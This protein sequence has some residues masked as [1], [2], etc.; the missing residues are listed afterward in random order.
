MIVKPETI[1]VIMCTYNGAEF[2][3]EQID[4]IINQVEKID[5]LLIIDDL[6]T[7]NTIQKL[8]A[9][10][11]K[12]PQLIKVIENKENLGYNKNFEKALQLASGTLIAIADQD[13]IWLPE[14]VKKLTNCFTNPQVMLAHCR[15]V[16]LQN[17]ELLYSRAKLHHHFTGNDSRQFFFFNHVMGHD[18]MLR[19]SLI[20]KA[21]PIPTGVYY[22]WWLAVQATCN[23]T[24]KGVDE[25]LTKHRI[26]NTNSFFNDSKSINNIKPNILFILNAFSNIKNLSAN[27]EGFLK[28]LINLL[29]KKEQQNKTGFYY[30]LFKFLLKNRKVVFAHKK[31]A[32]PFISYIKNA[33]KY[34]TINH[35]P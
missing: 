5:E 25:Y 23:G 19:K 24:I 35:I 28:E 10:Q 17:G 7:D 12:Y 22:D 1:S 8:H 30:P 13:D 14:K 9:W 18:I 6:S 26:H 29:T 3:N 27:A 33:I 15:S 2:I 16:R 21:L 31:R 4:S 20:N 34:A 32:L 11:N